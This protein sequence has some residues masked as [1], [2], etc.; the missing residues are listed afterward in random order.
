MNQR[1]SGSSTALADAGVTVSCVNNAFSWTKNYTTDPDFIAT[2]TGSS[3]QYDFNI[4]AL[5]GLGNQVI[6]STALT[7]VK[8]SKLGPTVLTNIAYLKNYVMQNIVV[9]TPTTGISDHPD[10]G[11][12]AVGNCPIS[13]GLFTL[14]GTLD[15]E[16]TLSLSG[17][18]STINN[19]SGTS[20][21]IQACVPYG[22]TSLVLSTK[23]ESGSSF[24][25]Q[26]TVNV[27]SSTFIQTLGSAN[28]GF[29][30]QALSPDLSSLVSA[31]TN[32]I[33]IS[34]D[35]FDTAMTASTGATG[36]TLATGLASYVQQVSP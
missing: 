4:Y 24:G 35:Q 21:N 28:E 27:T 16:S 26:Y 12:G 18:T 8:V 5:D 31:G 33:N 11:T 30:F 20:L 1:V 17:A 25:T 34:S 6:D 15:P 13:T 2:A 22:T 36:L 10:P 19:S 23:D 29:K 32:L 14:T 7:A 9:S 3:V